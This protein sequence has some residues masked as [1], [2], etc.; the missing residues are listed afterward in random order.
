MPFCSQ[1]GTKINEDANF[2]PSCGAGRGSSANPQ[3]SSSQSIQRPP[4]SSDYQAPPAFFQSEP[5][6]A[7]FPNLQIGKSWGRNDT[8]NLIVTDRRSIFA[9]LTNE[10]IN[11][12]VKTRRAKAS[13]EGKGFWGQ[14]KAQLTGFNNYTD[15]Y[16]NMNPEMIL[17][18]TPG[19]FFIDNAT[20]LKIKTRDNTDEEDSRVEYEIEFQTTA[21]KYKF[22]ANYDPEKDLKH[23]YGLK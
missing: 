6:K 9:K 2:C 13:A 3:V 10:L 1:C 14:Y 5:I 23:V 7:M 15:R 18:E 4:P 8:Y 22:T 17:A 11:E 20:I 16:V 19:N 12:T 21:Q